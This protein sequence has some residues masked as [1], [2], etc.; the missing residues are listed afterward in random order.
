MGLYRTLNSYS[1]EDIQWMKSSLPAMAGFKD[2]YLGAKF[3]FQRV[4][5]IVDQV[6]NWGQMNPGTDM[7]VLENYKGCRC[8]VDVFDDMYDDEL[9]AAGARKVD[10]R[11]WPE[12][13]V[14]QQGDAALSTK[15]ESGIKK[16]V[17]LKRIGIAWKL[18]YGVS[19][20]RYGEARRFEQIFRRTEKLHTKIV[21]RSECAE[22]LIRLNSEP[23]KTREPHPKEFVVAHS[24][25]NCIPEPP[26]VYGTTGKTTDKWSICD[27][28]TDSFIEQ[29]RQEYPYVANLSKNSS[30]KK[31]VAVDF[32]TFSVDHGKPGGDHTDIC[33]SWYDE[34]GDIHF[35]SIDNLEFR[36]DGMN[37]ETKSE[38]RKFFTTVT[39]RFVDGRDVT[40]MSAKELSNSIAMEEA[41]I[42]GLEQRE[43]KTKALVREIAERKANVQ[44]LV[45]YLDSLEPEAAK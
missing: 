14:Y 35:E 24:N 31:N 22:I 40:A 4:K 19:W 18:H 28:I 41:E 13:R 38:N 15:D 30:L 2:R 44:E 42:K 34:T 17:M 11:P 37:G 45:D 7:R 29:Y 21:L 27:E 3:F 6:N 32:E 26:V 36:R 5:V 33:R 43:F 25:S 1:S 8:F 10:N 12:K 23:I 39:R 9:R 16:W 20:N